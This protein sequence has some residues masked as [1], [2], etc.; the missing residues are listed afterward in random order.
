[1]PAETQFIFAL[2][3]VFQLKHFIAD[4]ALQT[5]WMVAGKSR[6]GAGFIYPLSAHVLV[7]AGLTLA[8]VLYVE[9]ALWY[10]ALFDFVAH[11]AMD[12][13]KAS[14]LLLG[15]YNDPAKQSFWLPFGFDQMVH[16]LT[17]YVI[18]W[19]LYVGEFG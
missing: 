4:Y 14:P 17:H 16:H 7:H 12:W 19:R 13:I 18:I 2:L 6:P 8:I 5:A 15:R 3:A 10:L 9:P 1:M 11:F